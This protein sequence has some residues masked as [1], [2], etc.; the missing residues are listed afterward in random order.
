MGVGIL[1]GREQ[2][3]L[4]NILFLL[5]PTLTPQSQTVASARPFPRRG[6]GQEGSSHQCRFALFLLLILTALPLCAEVPVP[7]LAQRV[8]DLTGT[9][10]PDQRVGLESRLAALE[11]EKGSQIAILL[12]PTTQPET[13]EQYSIRV[14]DA[15]KLGRKGIDDG[16]LV[17][18]A[19]QDRAARI[20]VGRG[21]EGVIPDA[22]ANRI[23]EDVMIPFFRQGDFYGG[24][25]AGLDRIA[26]LIRGE[27]LPAPKKQWKQTPDAGTGFLLSVFGGIF[28]GQMLR[29]MFG[30]FLGGL[31]AAAGAGA[32]AMLFDLPTLFALFVGAF[33]FIAVAGG[34]G[35]R[36]PGG[37]YGGS[38]G[39]Y[40]GYGGGAGDSG[41]FSGGGGGFAGGGA[42]GRW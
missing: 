40:G 1:G 10:T 24:L 26:A 16:V 21:L 35:R 19:R 42:S 12:I 22:V 27:P 32:V 9:L 13:I 3:E 11:A 20:E 18:L 23:V 25:S 4:G 8:T 39:W 41:G 29:L 34:G 28:G 38:G 15:W 14:V 6:R 31:I 17:L 37:R 33:V 36:G 2:F 7:P 5:A 30:A